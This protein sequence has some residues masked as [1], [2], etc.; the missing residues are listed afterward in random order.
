MS[1][2][3][4]FTTLKHLI[5]WNGG[6]TNFPYW[7]SVWYNC[8]GRGHLRISLCGVVVDGT[9]HQQS[10]PRQDLSNSPLFAWSQALS[11]SPHFHGAL[12]YVMPQTHLLPVLKENNRLLL[13]R[14]IH[15]ILCP[16]KLFWKRLSRNSE[17]MMVLL[18]HLFFWKRGNIPASAL[19]NAYSHILFII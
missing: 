11:I 17:Q 10:V 4:C 7:P 6:S 13:A 18:S 8:T 16:N 1:K 5:F 3:I 19:I 15:L 2:N 14:F 9:P 12:S